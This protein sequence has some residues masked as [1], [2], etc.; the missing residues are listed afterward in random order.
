[1]RKVI[2]LT[3]VIILLVA[4][5][6]YS[7]PGDTLWTRAYGGRW[8][9]AAYCVRQTS[10]GGFIAAGGTLSFGAGNADVYLLRTNSEGDTLWARTYGGSDLDLAVSVQKTSDDG[11][12]IAGGTFSFGAGMADVYLLKIDSVG[13]IIWTRTYGGFSLDAASYVEQT[14]D[15][16][17]IIAG[18]TMSFGAG[19]NDFYIIK[20]DSSG[21]SLWTRVYGGS[22]SDECRSIQQTSDGG[23]IVG[24]ITYSY[25]AGDADVYLLKTDPDGDT[26]WTRT[27]GGTDEDWCNYVQ[28][29]SDGGY[30]SAGW[31]MSFGAGWQDAYLLKID[32]SGDTLWTRT[33]GGET[34]DYGYSAQQTAD[35]GYVVAGGSYSYGAGNYDFYLIKTDP[36]GDTLWTRTYGGIYDETALFVQQTS[37]EGYIITGDTWSFGSGDADIYLVRVA[38]EELPAVSIDMIPDN[39]PVI[40]NPGGYF[41]FTGTVRNNTANN[42]TGDVWIMLD[43]P[44]IGMYGP[45]ERFNN[46]HLAPHQSVIRNGIRQDIP[47]FAP[48]GVYDY[49]AYGGNYPVFIADSAAF[50]FTVVA[51]AGGNAGS[52]N[53]SGWFDADSRPVEY[54]LNP[55]YPNPFN[56]ATMISFDLPISGNVRLAVYNLL[57]QKVATLVDGWTEEGQHAVNW[58]AAGY[59]SGIYFYRL[60]AGD[61]VFTKRMTLLK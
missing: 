11:Y 17:Y 22:G 2:F 30:I 20:T 8:F 33:F 52:W 18:Q 48:L 57:G 44:G 49:I 19:D 23:Y 16:G 53:L 42:L 51:P 5:M 25:G 60:T 61:R 37:D 54:S 34:S 21:D 39:P 31:T 32:P 13:N 10:D 47:V 50:Q 4:S 28:Q 41:T 14:S 29:T 27:Y 59:S 46:I 36:S 1:M 24:G 12:I 35:G 26:L 58:D 6:A 3:M 40:V 7:E 15:G 38:A 9:D 55:N 43:V 45:I 56:S